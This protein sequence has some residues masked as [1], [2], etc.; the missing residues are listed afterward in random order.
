M[1]TFLAFARVVYLGHQQQ[2]W[3]LYFVALQGSRDLISIHQVH[4][5]QVINS[6]RSRKTQEPQNYI[7][8]LKIYTKLKILVDKKLDQQAY[9]GPLGL[10]LEMETRSRD[11]KLNKN[12][13]CSQYYVQCWLFH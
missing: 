10:N 11:D 5:L 13:I 7:V 4:L 12:N 8:L 2:T 6:N 3:K 1:K 9:L